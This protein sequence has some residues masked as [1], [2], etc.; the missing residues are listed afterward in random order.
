MYGAFV[1]LIGGRLA[2][3]LIDN[4]QTGGLIAVAVGLEVGLFILAFVVWRNRRRERQ[5]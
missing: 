2:Y 5:P 3:R 4:Y 1:I